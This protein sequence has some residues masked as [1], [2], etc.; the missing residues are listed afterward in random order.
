M[1]RKEIMA[2]YRALPR[3]V[4]VSIW[5]GVFLLFYTAMGF[6][7]VPALTKYLLQNK[8]PELVKRP[9]HVEKV[10]FNPFT[11][12]MKVS[13]FE[14][15]QKGSKQQLAAARELEVNL[16]AISLVKRALVLS[17][18]KVTG[19]EIYISQDKKGE[20]NFQDIIS[21]GQEETPEEEESPFHFSLNNIQ[22]TDG[23]ITFRDDLK[24]VTHH[25]K[26]LKVG[27]PFVSNLKTRIRIYTKPYFSAVINGA[28]VEFEG[29]TRP[30]ARDH[31]TMLHVRLDQLDL[32]HYLAYFSDFI[33]FK[34]DSGTLAT[35]LDLV[36]LVKEDGTQDVELDGNITVSKVSASRQGRVFFRLEG[37]VLDFA[38]SNL[39]KKEIWFSKIH[40]ERP[41]LEV[42]RDKKGSLNLE[43][44]LARD[45]KTQAEA[46]KKDVS[47]ASGDLP[48]D[49]RINSAELAGGRVHFR[50]DAT[51]NSTFET[52]IGSI[53]FKLEDFGT[54]KKEPA[55]LSLVLDTGKGGK[56]VLDGGVTL[57]P[58][59]VNLKGN[60]TSLN[61]PAYHPYYRQ[62]LNA[63]ISKGKADI[64]ANMAFR[65]SEN[66]GPDV[67]L[68]D[69]QVEVSDLVL[70]EG[71]GAA[72]SGRV[73]LVHLAA[74]KLAG[75]EA[76]ITGSDIH[77]AS[78]SVNGLSTRVEIDKAGKLNL[79][80]IARKTAGENRE[81]QAKSTD[82]PFHF[83]LDNMSLKG[84]VCRFRDV[85][86]KK[87]VDLSIRDIGMELKGLDTSPGQR[88]G[89]T[90]SA[91]LGK[92]GRVELSGSTGLD[93]QKLD[94]AFDIR[95]LGLR[96]FQGYI[97]RFSNA[98]VYKGRLG[99]K[100][101]IE[102]VRSASDEFGLT[103]TGSGGLY[104]VSILDPSNR[105]PVFQWKKVGIRGLLF[106]NNPLTLHIRQV[107]L[108][109]LA[110]NIIF[111]GKGNLN[112]LAL[113]KEEESKKE[114]EIKTAGKS[115]QDIRIKKVSLKNCAM[116]FVDNSVTPPFRRSIDNINGE[117]EG[118]SSDPQMRAELDIKGLA[119]NSAT[120]EL[121]GQINPLA[122]PV[123]ADLVLKSQGI[124]M[125]RF[126]PYTAKFLG[127]VIEKGKLSNQL[128]IVI[129]DD[130]VTA[131]NRLFLD[132]FDFGRSVESEDAVN[133]PVKL[134]IALL[135]DRHG[136]INVEIPVH[137]RL[138]DPEFSLGGAIMKA[139]INLFVKAAT[140]PFSL[141]SAIA[142]GGEDMQ[143]IVFKP[144]SNRLDEEAKK[145]LQ[146]LAKALKDRPAL[147]VE[148]T[149]Y[150]DAVSD[151]K[152]LKD[153]RFMRL[154]RKEKMR[155][156]DD[157]Q[158]E[159]ITSVDDVEIKPEEFNKYLT[160]AYKEA[161]FKKPRM[162]IGLLKKQ[163]PEVM[164]KMLREHIK[165]DKGD[166]ENLAM[167][168]AQAVHDY[169]VSTGGIEAKRIFLTSSRHVEGS[170]EE[171]GSMVKLTLK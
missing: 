133:L 115:R 114:K 162:I 96:Q 75:G 57:L 28:P 142:G 103:A 153:L 59:S 146:G 26:E 117:I 34:I 169:L 23:S 116:K 7:A 122:K 126:S 102:M 138:D 152:G 105:K 112:V 15:G 74:L 128:H 143:Q 124:G 51:G 163:P 21:N 13:G 1:N 164:E 20:F 55:H 120:M 94:G 69:I 72:A 150:Y 89:F 134:A 50:D 25:I 141:L 86:G 39:L 135:K 68:S 85:S 46:G 12:D 111:D 90:L 155:D 61:L 104:G 82:R 127:Y 67:R 44:L 98:V 109:E 121:T 123:Y 125:T 63:H 99:F 42:T 56:C 160:K 136:K 107:L 167:E 148:L 154:L 130:K 158:R 22:I 157:D 17:A 45:K 156:L 70:Q 71:K 31:S 147:K 10:S 139:I 108:E 88:C 92:K 140:S 29:Q 144:G 78:L 131:E 8:V 168:R 110:G 165:I 64:S 149:G 11:L 106:K 97:S 53:G 27:I 4:K 35:D 36:F 43:D 76:D 37:L 58:V 171:K 49:F 87:P 91:G 24:G 65:L 137:G 48:L 101:K 33:N 166:L 40:I 73:P 52:T 132:Q 60:L 54:L 81:D 2:N 83:S 19:P 119:D 18:I 16:E 32:A 3:T 14:I 159:K 62:F 47:K 161:P 170:K 100:G 113:L 129:K 5:L 93:L 145:K 38:P 151:A 118:L 30:F 66:S 6:L 79:A 9:V 95:M 41:W 77:L 80:E 84:G